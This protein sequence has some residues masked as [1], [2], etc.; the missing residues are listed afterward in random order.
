M[1][2]VFFLLR[3]GGL[4]AVVG[5]VY[6]LANRERPRYLQTDVHQPKDEWHPEQYEPERFE[7][8]EVGEHRAPP[9]DLVGHQV[10][11]KDE[12]PRS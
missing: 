1:G 8:A 3:L 7:A 6:Y 5:L 12:S 11:F 2:L 9:E 10:K 4:A